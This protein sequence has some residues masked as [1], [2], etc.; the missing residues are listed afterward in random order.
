MKKLSFKVNELITLELKEGKTIVY[1]A[2]KE[3]RQCKSLV[4][5]I[6]YD[7]LFDNVEFSSIDE[8]INLIETKKSDYEIDIQESL[9][10]PEMEFW[11]HCSSFDAWTKHN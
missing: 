4:I 3:F 9:V 6:P 1:I 11:A 10:N 5:N 7:I 2:G 8:F